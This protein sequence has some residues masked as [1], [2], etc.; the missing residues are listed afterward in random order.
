MVAVRVPEQRYAWLALAVT[1]LA[2]PGAAILAVLSV[3]PAGTFGAAG[4]MQQAM[5]ASAEIVDRTQENT[6]VAPEQSTEPPST[7]Q[8]VALASVPA[9]ET[10]SG[11][12]A[13]ANAE[14]LLN[15]PT[16]G[17]ARATR[18]GQTATAE[19]PTAPRSAFIPV[20][21][22]SLVPAD[23][24]NGETPLPTATPSFQQTVS[25]L[26]PDDCCVAYLWAADSDH[27]LYY[28]RRESGTAGTATAGTWSV[29]VETGEESLLTPLY[30]YF[31]SDR[32][33]VAVPEPADRRMRIRELTTEEEWV[34]PNVPSRVLIGPRG[35]HIAFTLR[36][37]E[38]PLERGV[39]GRPPQGTAR[40][41]GSI[42]IWIA[43]LRGTGAR[44][45]RTLPGARIHDWLPDGSAL[46]VTW[47]TIGR[48]ETSL[49]L[50]DVKTGKVA[51]QTI[52]PRL[53]SSRLSPDGEWVAYVA[54]FTGSAERDGLW[55]RHVH[56]DEARRLDIWGDY[57][58]APDSSSLI[59][60]P[61]RPK[62]ADGDRF[63]RAYVDGEPPMPMTDPDETPFAITNNS[64]ELSPDGKRVVFA[65]AADYSLWILQLQPT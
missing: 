19:Q 14:S 39:V 43:D 57:R 50:L 60:L 25:K 17:A 47:R 54:A 7:P 15:T 12:A 18:E 38:R 49:G 59:V 32:S 3:A 45:I 61:P 1:V 53:L 33:T 6:P 4:T 34:L 13:T 40:I 23:T 31:S 21:G 46:L 16:A 58:W 30:G 51:L 37:A 65:S 5:A 62:G 44:A 55:V 24:V 20:S 64:W 27:V 52:A 35:E 48:L 41:L 56:G 10:G 2:A 63:W 29:N 28:D 8:S 36:P 26:T 42:A 11:G 9:P 22:Q